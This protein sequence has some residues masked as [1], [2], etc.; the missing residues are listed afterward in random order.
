MRNLVAALIFLFTGVAWS[1]T[2]HVTPSVSA[3]TLGFSSV[4]LSLATNDYHKAVVA[5]LA[6]GST[7]RITYSAGQSNLGAYSASTPIMTA[8]ALSMTQS[9]RVEMIIF[10]KNVSTITPETATDYSVAWHQMSTPYGEPTVPPEEGPYV[11][12]P[13]EPEGTGTATAGTSTGG[14]STAGTSTAGT[15]TGGTSTAG[16]STGGETGGTTA[17]TSTGGETGGGGTATG[18]GTG[19]GVPVYS[20]RLTLPARQVAT[21]WTVI[22]S[23]ANGLIAEEVIQVGAGQTYTIDINANEPFTAESVEWLALQEGGISFVPGPSVQGQLVA[24]ASSPLPSGPQLIGVAAG[25]PF[26]APRPDAPPREV[27]G[28]DR[29]RID[30]GQIA[31]LSNGL[32][33]IRESVNIAAGKAEATGTNLQNAIN[34]L[35]KDNGRTLTAAPGS[36]SWTESIAASMSSIQSSTNALAGKFAFGVGSATTLPTWS[37][38]VGIGNVDIN[39]NQYSGGFSIVRAFL[40]VLVVLWFVF[41][42]IRTVKGAMS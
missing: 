28:T 31:E 23:G 42:L 3:T 17:G 26:G 8:A 25:T 33:S 41:A 5:R 36:A 40:L 24:Q 32:S 29:T 1:Q 13:E 27:A 19:T 34:S 20:A 30:E 15:S 39:L 37:I 16:T 12:P 21:T 4:P 2:N 22:V 35:G 38:P 9:F 7:Q 18:G 6:D 10:R 14:T 11:P